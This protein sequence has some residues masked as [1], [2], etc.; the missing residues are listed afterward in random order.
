MK[1]KDS[2]KNYD[3]KIR[4]YTNYSYRQSKN[5][6]KNFSS[7]PAG[8]ENEKNLQEHLTKELEACANSVTKEEFTFAKTNSFT[9]NILNLVFLTVA[10]IFCV[11]DTIGAF[12]DKAFGII[13][14][15][16]AVLLGAINIFSGISANTLSSLIAKK[17]TGNNILAVR[18]ADKEAKKRLVLV[19]NS[20]S[21]PEQKFRTAPFTIVSA[22]GF[23]ITI[24][25]LFLNAYNGLI[26]D[27]GNVKYAS[28]ALLVF[29]PAAIIP[30][31]ADKKTYS[32]GASKNLSGCF[33]SIAVLKYLKDNS[34]E[35][36]NTEI[37]VLI[38]SA[39]EYSCAGAKAYFSAHSSHTDDMPTVFIGIDSI[40]GEEANLAPIGN[41]NEALTFIKE[42]A[43][44]AGIAL[45]AS[46]IQGKYETD[47][48]KFKGKDALTLTSLGADYEKTADTHEDM[49]VKTIESALKTVVSGLFIYDEK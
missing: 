12:G 35:M 21:I 30:L 8:S 36:E 11:L 18:N 31:F 20:D 24:A 23:V 9:D 37:C 17:E 41:G 38:L 16:V 26:S 22:I 7:R 39:H 5:A 48:S 6:C 28:L 43:E 46:P 29:I 1:A 2:V 25:V 10:V 15:V 44:D 3:S 14:A 45:S 13:I 40:A 49:R 4:E 19:A 42:G 33:S 34:I 32:D 27:A 47:L